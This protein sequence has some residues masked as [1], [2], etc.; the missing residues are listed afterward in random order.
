[1]IKQLFKNK[2]YIFFFLLFLLITLFG[3]SNKTIPFIF[4]DEFGYWSSAAYFAGY[5]W[6]GITSQI[7]YY[8]YGYGVI[9]SVLLRLC[10]D[11]ILA[12]R[13]AI[14]LNAIWWILEFYFLTKIGIYLFSRTDRHIT[15][16]FSA[17]ATMY[18]G[19]IAQ[20]NYT[21]PEVFLG[22]LFVLICYFV[23]KIYEKPTYLNISLVLLICIYTTSVHNR[24]IAILISLVIFFLILFFRKKISLPMLVMIVLEVS[25]GLIITYVLKNYIVNYVW[26]NGNEIA[27]NSVSGQ[28]SK[29]LSLLSFDGLKALFVSFCGKLYYVF[30]SSFG[31]ICV[32][33]LF[34][35]SKIFPFFIKDKSEIYIFFFLSLLGSIGISA[36]FMMYPEGA[37]HLVYG[38]YSENVIVIFIFMGIMVL[39]QCCENSRFLRIIFA[40]AMCSCLLT[41]FLRKVFADYDLNG[42][43]DI[44]NVG[45][46]RF[47]SPDQI[48]FEAGIIWALFFLTIFVLILKNKTKIRVLVGGILLCMLWINIGSGAV[49]SFEDSTWKTAQRDS[50]IC[51]EVIKEIKEYENFDYYALK[52]DEAFTTRF[53]GNGIQ[54]LLPEIT[55][56]SIESE[57]EIKTFD[58]IVIGASYYELD[59]RFKQLYSG[60]SYSIW[61]SEM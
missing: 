18:C 11:T 27:I 15:I 25:V 28:S 19:N 38:R 2:L 30:V 26:L 20:K 10:R 54:F 5:D 40:I 7:A 49:K 60:D 45:I 1:M 12:Y 41:L 51:A 32:G 57:D 9:L 34:C 61:I 59:E 29:L 37:T 53:S 42:A 43:A 44:N 6:S 35:F 52:I 17:C 55:V 8:S 22:F 23:I 56:Q 33:G 36:I 31:L 58:A 50:V 47:V 46:Y 21:W 24:T 13:L 16:F 3:I 48:D 4:N 14:V 39:Y